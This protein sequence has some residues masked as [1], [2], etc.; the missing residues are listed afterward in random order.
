MKGERIALLILIALLGTSIV[1]E[2]YLYQQTSSI[3]EIIDN[4]ASVEQIG[5]KI[6]KSERLIS[7]MLSHEDLR[8][9]EIALC[10]YTVEASE[11]NKSRLR[12][13]VHHVKRLSFFSYFQEN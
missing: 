7:S 9:I 3:L 1:A 11:I 2:L 12:D 13:S 8:E 6:H 5:E 4:D 10:D